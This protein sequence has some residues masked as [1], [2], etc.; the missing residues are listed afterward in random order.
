[1]ASCSSSASRS[2]SPASRSTWSSDVDRRP[3]DGAPSCVTTHRT[4]P[5]WICSLFRP[6]AS[7]CS[8]AWSSS[9]SHAATL[10]GSTSQQIRPQNGL[11]ARS[12]RRSLG[13]RPQLEVE[14]TQRGRRLW[15]VHGPNRS[16]TTSIRGPERYGISTVTV[17]THSAL[18]LAAR[19][20]LPH[21]SVSSA[22]SL[23][24]SVGVIG[25]GSPPSSARRACN[26]GSA[27]TAFTA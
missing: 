11:H 25:M 1:M 18:I 5:P 21:F 24:N 22:T 4:S 8:S 10:S 26:L 14:R 17:S 23:P 3:R 20:T 6:L 2:L 9:G 19:I 27:N 12:R 13:M 15:A 16:S 7:T